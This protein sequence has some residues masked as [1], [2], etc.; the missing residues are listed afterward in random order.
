MSSLP[1]LNETSLG[2]W[3][4][5]GS[6]SGD[7]TVAMCSPAILVLLFGGLVI[8]YDIFKGNLRDVGFRGFITLLLTGI[9]MLFCYAGLVS[10]S[11]AI[12]L[13]PVVIVVGLVVVVIL[14]LMLTSPTQP[15]RPHPSHLPR[16]E[17]VEPEPTKGEAYR[18]VMDGKGMLR[19]LI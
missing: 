11:W 15:P 7:S 14:T 1:L 8:A 17:P 10:I 12:V 2:G 6:T 9:V 19:S 3:G 4:G 5:G 18:Y 13:I 16:P